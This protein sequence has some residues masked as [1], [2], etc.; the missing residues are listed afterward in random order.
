MM[1]ILMAAGAYS[2]TQVFPVNLLT[3]AIVS[4]RGQNAAHLL[5]HQ[6][7]LGLVPYDLLRDIVRESFDHLNDLTFLRAVHP[8]F[9]PYLFDLHKSN[10][11]TRE[12]TE[13]DGREFLLDL[14]LH[15]DRPEFVES[16]LQAEALQYL[17]ESG[18]EL[19]P[20]HLYIALAS[21]D[22]RALIDF[23]VEL[24]LSVTANAADPRQI[25]YTPLEAAILMRKPKAAVRL[26]YHGAE[27]GQLKHEVAVELRA[28][29]DRVFH[30]DQ[31]LIKYNDTI[32]TDAEGE[33]F[34]IDERIFKV[35]DPQKFPEQLLTLV[36]MT[37]GI[38]KP[39][40]YLELS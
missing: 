33:T 26:I 2:S 28:C 37:I 22:S 13:A 21:E 24:G 27:V 11:A 5:R 14:V 4:A 12:Q 18:C 30:I 1:D 23:M 34:P 40:K 9:T 20:S 17:V 32:I 16:G 7:R 29:Y 25:L 10:V 3:Q 6:A 31:G 38:P 35:D 39:R 15:V 36:A 19:T 8:R